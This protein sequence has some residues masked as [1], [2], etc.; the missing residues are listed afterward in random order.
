MVNIEI[1]DIILLTFNLEEKAMEIEFGQF[2]LNLKNDCL[3]VGVKNNRIFLTFI[4]KHRKKTRWRWQRHLHHRFPRNLPSHQ[5]E[6]LPKIF[7]D[8]I[9]FEDISLAEFDIPMTTDD[10]NQDAIIQIA[11]D[12]HGC[13]EFYEKQDVIIADLSFKGYQ[14]QLV[15]PEKLIELFFEPD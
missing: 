12:I 8:N 7:F 6:F 2:E 4:P 5:E 3:Q 14:T 9:D 15:M 11:I 10:I 1:I 13:L